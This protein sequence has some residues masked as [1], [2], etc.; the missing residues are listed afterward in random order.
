[1][2]T[3]VPDYS[4]IKRVMISFSN[5]LLDASAGDIAPEFEDFFDQ[6]N[7]VLDPD[8]LQIAVDQTDRL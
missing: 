7:V 1:M 2:A 5:D 4:S 8:L 6:T 3:S